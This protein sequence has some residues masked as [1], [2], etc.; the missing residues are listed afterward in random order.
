MQSYMAVGRGSVRGRRRGDR[1]AV[2]LDVAVAIGLTLESSQ[3]ALGQAASAFSERG[4]SRMVEDLQRAITWEGI[5]E[6][7]EAIVPRKAVE[8]IPQD[9][10]AQVKNF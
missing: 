5:Q 4:A 10:Q 7:E 2:Q 9:L 8:D 3:Q 6:E 1:P